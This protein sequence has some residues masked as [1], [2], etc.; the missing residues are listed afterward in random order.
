EPITR[1]TEELERILPPTA[2]SPAARCFA[3]R[4]RGPDRRLPIVS[5]ALPL[6]LPTPTRTLATLAESFRYHC[7]ASNYSPATV[8][9]YT[10]A[11]SDFD[12]FLAGNSLP[13]VVRAIERE[14]IEKFIG[15]VLK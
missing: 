6:R 14:H 11:V 9:I 1:P 13:Q 7:A 5:K 4:R 3:H 12:A 8:R 15:S 10:T 2:R